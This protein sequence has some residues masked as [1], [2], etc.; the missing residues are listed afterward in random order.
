MLFFFSFCLAL[1]CSSRSCS[2]Y[3][4]FWDCEMFISPMAAFVFCFLSLVV[5]WRFSC[6]SLGQQH[7][8][9]LYIRS[10]VRHLFPGESRDSPNA[11]DIQVPCAASSK[12]VPFFLVTSLVLYRPSFLPPVLCLTCLRPTSFLP[13]SRPKPKKHPPPH[14]SVCNG[15]TR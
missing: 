8:R 7:V 13:T 14:I 10:H 6:L 5:F 15:G 1:S 12:K 3:V 9:N 11:S 2:R 4:I